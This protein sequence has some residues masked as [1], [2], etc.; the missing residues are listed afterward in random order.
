MESK[1]TVGSTLFVLQINCAGHFVKCFSITNFCN[2][3]G[4]QQAKANAKNQLHLC[5]LGLKSFNSPIY[6]SG[7]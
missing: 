2:F 7:L 1:T 3:P 6:K 4:P 5:V